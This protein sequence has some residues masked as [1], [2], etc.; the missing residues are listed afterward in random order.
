MRVRGRRQTRET[1]STEL[2]NQTIGAVDYPQYKE[3][4]ILTGW[5]LG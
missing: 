1:I 4:V 5:S 3:N 2:S